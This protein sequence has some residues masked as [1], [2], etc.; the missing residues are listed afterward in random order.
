MTNLLEQIKPYNNIELI[1]LFDNKK[2]SIGLKRDEMLKLAQGEYLVFI[3]DDD[4]IS[5]DYVKEIMN[6]LYDNPNTDC[7]VFENLTRIN[8]GDGILCKYGI[9]F[10]YGYINDGKE[11]RG[12]PAHTM[13]YK[14]SIAKKHNFNDIQNGEDKDWVLR[15]Y[16]DIKHQ[17][18]INKTLYFYDAEYNSTSETNYLSEEIIKENIKKKFNNYPINFWNE[19]HSNNDKYWLS[20]Y[21]KDDIFYIHK[22]KD[23]NNLKVLDIGVGLGYFTKELYDLGNEVYACDISEIALSNVKN[24][25]KTYL[26]SEL[27]NIE[28]V[29][30]AIC[31]LVFQHCNDNEI[32]R[33]INEVNLRNNG[34][35]TFQFAFLRENEE[36]NE[37]IKNLIK[38]GTHF[39]RSLDKIIDIVEKSNKK[40]IQIL[41]PIH[42]YGDE[43]CSWYIV[44]VV[45]K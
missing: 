18:R 14:S 19:K 31:N 38:N 15:A 12:K 17:T 40:I 6:A 23:V 13:V 41:D 24:Y 7:V 32:T 44:K 16:L 27:K 36:P 21:K 9:E 2:R 22:L 8:G 34:I 20:G 30:L 35:F 26:T 43:N 33:I 4:R 3:D 45:N 5:E 1:G 39:Y 28:P 11:W 25:A 42:Y 29:D 10:E 37:K